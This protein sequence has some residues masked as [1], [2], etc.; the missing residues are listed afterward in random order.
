LE[1][2]AAVERWPRAGA[3][4]LRGG[5]LRPAMVGRPRGSAA[6]AAARRVRGEEERE[7]EWT[8]EAEGARAWVKA[9]AGY[10]GHGVPPGGRR[11]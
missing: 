2:A 6:T 5:E 8:I 3:T 4:V 9:S 11:R 7:E 1:R 10:G